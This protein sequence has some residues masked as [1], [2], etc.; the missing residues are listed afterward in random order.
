VAAD[1][2][3]ETGSFL[4]EE[5]YNDFLQEAI[6]AIQPNITD[7]IIYN[8]TAPQIVTRTQTTTQVIYPT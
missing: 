1:L 5:D 7:S 8:P 6:D 3:L 4:S 2:P